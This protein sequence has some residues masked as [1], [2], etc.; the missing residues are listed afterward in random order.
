MSQSRFIEQ[1]KRLAAVYPKLYKLRGATLLVEVLPK[2]D[3]KTS[4]GIIIGQVN[5]QRANAE[6]FRRGLG[7]VLLQ[8]DGYEDGSE[9]EIK[10][11]MVIMLPY[12]PMYLS[13][14]PGLQDYTKN[15]LAL[16]NE[17]DV[18]FYY[19][20]MEDYHKSRRVLDA[21]NS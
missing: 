2:D 18:L 10:E 17:G 1:F 4:G 3:L 9:M 11:G 15:S 16:V 8:G 5:N 21:N 13:E 14:F 20:S 12:Q 19:N 6:E 7:L